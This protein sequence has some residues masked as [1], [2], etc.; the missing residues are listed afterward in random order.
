M[1][2]SSNSVKRKV[3]NLQFLQSKSRFSKK[4]TD[5]TGDLGFT[6]IDT[7]FEPSYQFGPAF[8][9]SAVIY[10]KTVANLESGL[11]RQTCCLDVNGGSD[12]RVYI[13]HVVARNKLRKSWQRPAASAFIAEKK[14]LATLFYNKKTIPMH[15]DDWAENSAAKR[16][17]RLA[18]REEVNSG[19]RPSGPTTSEQKLD[20]EI[21]FENGKEGKDARTFISP[22][23]VAAMQGGWAMPILKQALGVPYILNNVRIQFIASPDLDTLRAVFADIHNPEHTATIYV[24][25]DDGLMAI[26]TIHGLK[27][28]KN[29]IE[30]CDRSLVDSCFQ[31]V[32]DMTPEEIVA[33][34]IAVTRAQ[35]FWP[36]KVTHPNYRRVKQKTWLHALEEFEPSGST[37]TTVSNTVTNIN[38][39]LAIAENIGALVL[40]NDDDLVKELTA[41]ALEGGLKIKYET[42]KV[43]QQ[44]DF[45]KFFPAFNTAGEMEALQCLGPT[46]RCHGKK[47][48]DFIYKK[49][50]WEQSAVNFNTSI[51]NGLVHSGN[52]FFN[53]ALRNNQPLNS[54][55]ESVAHVTN[56]QKFMTG[57]Q[58]GWCDA[59]QIAL[60]YS[61]NLHDLEMMKSDLENMQVGYVLHAPWLNKIMAM[62]YGSSDPKGEPPLLTVPLN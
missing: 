22:G 58:L 16:A 53:H 56:M 10:D 36:L 4:K 24:F 20:V 21:K 9:T 2:S 23:T 39:A 46:V 49:L 7:H 12:L 5:F 41:L 30:S 14:R 1:P 57:R 8:E 51:V 17:L 25:S 27:W 6:P 19:Q 34:A 33:H 31:A 55:V 48:R 26:R 28:L 47:K 40:L 62:D 37:L 52:H 42:C 61:L 60:R 45:L 18:M 35:F 43:I 59:E 44:M 29:D 13:N 15:K 3:Q 38:P 54:K 32:E 50:G 11:S